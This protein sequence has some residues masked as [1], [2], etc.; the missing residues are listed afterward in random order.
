MNI[1]SDI[2]YILIENL[3]IKKYR[4]GSSYVIMVRV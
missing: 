4:I 3:I 1:N 2:F